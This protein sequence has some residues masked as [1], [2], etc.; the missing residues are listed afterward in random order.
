MKT[1]YNFMP[2]RRTLTA[3]TFSRIRRERPHVWWNIFK[4]PISGFPLPSKYPYLHSR[5]G[6]H[7][8]HAFNLTVPG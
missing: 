3:D 6:T 2:F 7:L 5:N 8:F 1:K 4:A